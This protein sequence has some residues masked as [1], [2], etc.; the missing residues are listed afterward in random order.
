MPDHALS[1]PSRCSSSAA[2]PR[3][4][5]PRSAAPRRPRWP[6]LPNTAVDRTI[7]DGAH[8]NDYW[9][10]NAPPDA[11]NHLQCILIASAGDI[12]I[13]GFTIRNPNPILLDRIG[14]FANSLGRGKVT[15]GGN[16][17]A[18]GGRASGLWRAVWMANGF[19]ADVN[20][21][22]VRTFSVSP[23]SSG[24]SFDI[25]GAV[26]GEAEAPAPSPPSSR[27][28]Q[29]RDRDLD[30]S[31]RLEASF[32]GG[33]LTCSITRDSAPYKAL[34]MLETEDP[35][36]LDAAMKKL[37]LRR[38]KSAVAAAPAPA[39]PSAGGGGAAAGAEPPLTVVYAAPMSSSR[40]T[41]VVSVAARAPHQRAPRP[42][43]PA[44][45]APEARAARAGPRRLSWLA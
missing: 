32:G 3:P 41:G 21:N 16:A 36:A 1:P 24:F 23:A 5:R 38:G 30:R 22:V 4:R 29:L 44:L 13:R 34:S 15:I 28:G 11:G 17:F 10:F 42:R 43:Q 14:V 9:A 40:V 39:K 37:H 20:H 19:D 6:H 27:R 8:D 33:A 45:R 25:C 31:V 12:E 2:A 35:A 18:D 26:D 7:L